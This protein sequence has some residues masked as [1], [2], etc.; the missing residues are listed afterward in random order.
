MKK[1]YLLL[2]LKA[3]ALLLNSRPDDADTTLAQQGVYDLPPRLQVNEDGVVADEIVR[4]SEVSDYLWFLGALN[5]EVY[6]GH[7]DDTISLE[8]GDD[9]ARGGGGNDVIVATSGNNEFHGRG[10]ND[11]LWGG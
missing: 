11:H 1:T 7:R 5:Q 9:Y 6:A 4:G 2:L 8:G 3:H 10:G